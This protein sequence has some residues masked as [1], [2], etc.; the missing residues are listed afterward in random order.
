MIHR[1]RIEEQLAYFMSVALAGLVLALAPVSA[2][3]QVPVKNKAEAIQWLDFEQALQLAKKEKKILL[4]D[5]YT[6]W[7]GWCKVMD[8]ETYGNPKVIKYAREKMVMSKVNAESK[9][10]TSFKD[11][12]FTYQALAMALGVRGYPATIFIDSNGELIT[13]VP[14]FIRP[15]DFLPIAEFLAEGHYKSMNFEAYKQKRKT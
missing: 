8:R 10:E 9:Q 6:D 7:C 3:G 13:S 11:Q 1:A 14:G 12:K 15:D 4:V 2:I 5:F